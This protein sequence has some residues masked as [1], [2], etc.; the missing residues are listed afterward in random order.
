MRYERGPGPTGAGHQG[1]F[2]SQDFR[3]EVLAAAS[4]LL[5]DLNNQDYLQEC[6][7]ELPWRSHT[8]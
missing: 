2:E 8:R 7:W 6:R 4:A 3:N 1:R 5:C